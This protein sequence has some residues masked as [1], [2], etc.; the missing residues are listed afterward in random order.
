[1]QDEQATHDDALAETGGPEPDPF[2]EVPS[3]PLGEGASPPPPPPEGGHIPVSEPDEAQRAA[4]AETQRLAEEKAAEAAAAEGESG[5]GEFLEEPAED[6]LG[7]MGA[8]EPEPEPAGEPEPEA[9]AEP[10][11]P[12]EEPTPEPETP[13][14]EPPPPAVEPE[15]EPEPEPGPT[16]PTE[17]APSGEAEPEVPT[18]VETSG[19]PPTG[20]NLASGESEGDPEAGAPE[21]GAGPTTAEDKPKPKR[22]R[23]RTRKKDV[24]GRR[25]YVILKLVGD[26]A[27][28]PGGVFR[29]T[30]EE[31]FE[32]EVPI[33]DEGSEPTLIAS[34]SA[35][36][37]L[38]VAYR[39][40]TDNGEGSFELVPVPVKLF[41]P[42]SVEGKVPETALAI[43]VG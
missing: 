17:P 33:G 1:M 16:E 25:G 35:E 7:N 39:Q 10:E 41:R 28:V 38:R 20:G 34:R 27:Q 4:E 19:S 31:A 9:P 36:M 30:W 37:A 21:P 3:D 14:E 32:R 15:P 6:D 11:P 24:K 29:P 8:P 40:L 23:R 12:A 2:A 5:T 18:G 22:K 42:R 13:V 26:P 43:K